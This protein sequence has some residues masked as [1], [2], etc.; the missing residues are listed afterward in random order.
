MSISF[1]QK[2]FKSIANTGNG[3][4]GEQTLFY[5][6]QQNN[7]VWAE[8]SGGAIVKGFL[9]AK[10]IENDALDIRYEHINIT[11][12]IMTGLCLSRPEVLPDGRIRLHEK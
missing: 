12:E 9:V 5:Y 1:H 6:Q 2:I 11:G 10:V 3:Q 8:Y 7:V 4:V